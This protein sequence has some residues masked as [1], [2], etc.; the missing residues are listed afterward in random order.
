MAVCLLRADSPR[1]V[2]LMNYNQVLLCCRNR[3]VPSRPFN[4]KAENLD[5][6]VSS[7]TKTKIIQRSYR[8]FGTE[9]RSVFSAEM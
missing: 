3:I 8:S 6:N 7:K 4:Y 5:Q 9:K 2:E 1:D